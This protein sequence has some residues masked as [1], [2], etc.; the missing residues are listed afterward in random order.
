VNTDEIKVDN[1]KLEEKKVEDNV[2]QDVLQDCICEDTKYVKDLDSVSQNMEL[3]P[4][5]YQFPL[6]EIEI[7]SQNHCW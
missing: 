2:T 7:C 6:Q 1:K 3:F 5:L 4:E